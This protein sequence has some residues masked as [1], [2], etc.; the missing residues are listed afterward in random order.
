MLIAPIID[1]IPN[2]CTEKIANGNALP[3]CKTRGGYKVQPEA[4]A[5]P[6]MNNVLASNNTPAT[7]I[8]K[9]ILF[10]RGNAISGAPIIIGIIQLA[11]PTKAGITAPNTMTKACMVVMELKN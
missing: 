11:K 10:I 6:S 5:P 1:E 4:G 8:Q 7:S 2:K 9:L 3:V